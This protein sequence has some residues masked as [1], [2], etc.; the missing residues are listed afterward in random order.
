MNNTSLPYR[1][2]T[3]SIHLER[4]SYRA[5]RVIVEADD[6][7]SF[8]NAVVR[9]SKAGWTVDTRNGYAHPVF[10]SFK[11]AASYMRGIVTEE[12]AQPQRMAA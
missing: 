1:P 11:E 5:A 6:T 8:I 7:G 12:T 9:L 4:L 2:A 3:P 10:A